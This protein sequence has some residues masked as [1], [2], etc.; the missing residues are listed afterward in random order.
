MRAL[1]IALAL[2]AAGCGDR[3]R[4]CNMGTLFITMTFDGTT[5]QSDTI[6]LDVSVE[7][8]APKLNSFL[9][10]AGPISGTVQIGFPAGYPAGQRV[11]LFARARIAGTLVGM[12]TAELVL[13]AG[14]TSL[15]LA[16]PGDTG[17]GGDAG[18]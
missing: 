13:A 12:A 18:P 1:A 10:M 9:R 4:P 11:A 16:L 17:D 3:I 2:W 6:E 8:A 7:G 14:C 5:A 15:S